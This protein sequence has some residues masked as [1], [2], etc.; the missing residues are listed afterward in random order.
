MMRVQ[1]NNHKWI[2]IVTVGLLLFAGLG[3]T[4]SHWM[5]AIHRDPQWQFDGY[6]GTS[7][8]LLAATALLSMLA[9]VVAVSMTLLVPGLAILASIAI[10]YC[11]LS[12]LWLPLVLILA[13]VL[14]AGIAQGQGN[15]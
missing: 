10:L 4:D 9:L 6:L 13:V 3:L 2:V 12:L 5:W 11:G 8:L 14:L 7:I 1:K 15:I